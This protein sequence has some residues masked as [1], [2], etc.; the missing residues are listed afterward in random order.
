MIHLASR[1]PR[2]RELLRQLGVEFELLDPA[3]DESLRPGESP[4]EHARRLAMAKAEAGLA[5]LEPTSGDVVIGADTIVVLNDQVLGKPRDAAHA[6][7]MLASLSNRCHRVVSAVAVACAAG[8]TERVSTSRVC[9]RAL[10]D[11]ERDAYV[12]TGEPLDKAGGYGIQGRAAAFV[13]RLEGSYSGVV[14]LPLYETAELL[15]EAGV[16]VFPGD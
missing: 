14:G 2:R 3:V 9:F 1:S 8:T 15:G 4:E 7:Q 11:R 13:T 12:A 5:I 10:T 6:R 16:Q